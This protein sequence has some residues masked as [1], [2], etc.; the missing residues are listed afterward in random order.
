MKKK[1]Y[2]IALLSIIKL[3][4]NAQEQTPV[5]D[6]TTTDKSWSF[7]LST[8]LYL[9]KGGDYT[10]MPDFKVDK[11][12]L[13]LQARYNYEDDQTASL[14]AGYN[15]EVGDKLVWKASPMIGAVAGNS[16]GVAPGIVYTL[17]YKSIEWYSESEYFFSVENNDDNYFYVSSDL[18]YSFT[19]FFW[20][21]VELN[22]SHIFKSTR[23]VQYGI[24]IGGTYKWFIFNGCV[25][26]LG[27]SDTSVGLTFEVKF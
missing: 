9:F 1:I 24:L 25:Y 3:N 21:G 20:L 12:R 10:I 19:D 23:D 27:T 5:A 4:V 16:N 18:S 14:W 13:H 22:R 8:T 26:E 7:D 2:I 17:T 11:N 6:T 15:F